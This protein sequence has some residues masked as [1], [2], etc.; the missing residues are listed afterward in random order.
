[1]AQRPYDLQVV[2]PERV[3]L[4]ESVVSLIAPGTEGKFGILA[5]H[6]PLVAELGIGELTFTRS[7]GTRDELAIANGFLEVSAGGVMVL[8]DVAE[9]LDDIDVERAEEARQRAERRMS[10]EE[11]EPDVDTERAR[12]ALLRAL[13]RL[14]VAERRRR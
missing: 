8:A 4:S 1:M 5:R 7:D 13:N 12:L 9:R 14:K 6:A 11:A 10:A 3:V 2:T